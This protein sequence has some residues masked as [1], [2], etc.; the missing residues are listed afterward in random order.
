LEFAQG[1]Y[2]QSTETVIDGGEYKTVMGINVMNQ[3]TLNHSGYN[4]LGGWTILNI[5][6]LTLATNNCNE[7]RILDGSARQIPYQSFGQNR[8]NNT[9]EFGLLVQTEAG[10]NKTLNIYFN[11]SDADTTPDYPTYHFFRD[12]FDDGNTVGWNNVYPCIGTSYNQGINALGTYGLNPYDDNTCSYSYAKSIGNN[13]RWTVFAKNYTEETM[14]IGV[15][16]SSGGANPSRTFAVGGTLQNPTGNFTLLEIGCFSDGPPNSCRVRANYTYEAEKSFDQTSGIVMWINGPGNNITWDEVNLWNFSVY[17]YPVIDIWNF[18]DPLNLTPQFFQCSGGV[19]EQLIYNFTFWKERTEDQLNNNH[20]Y[21]AGTFTTYSEGS[22]QENISSSVSFNATSEVDMCSSSTNPDIRVI[23]N[24]EYVRPEYDTRFYYFFNSTLTPNQNIKLYLLE[25]IYADQVNFHV[26][27]TNDYPLGSNV[28]VFVQRYF[29]STGDYVTVAMLRP[30]EIG[31][32]A[33]YLR[34]VDAWYKFIVTQN[35]ETIYVTTPRKIT[36]TDVYIRVPLSS[37]TNILEKFGNLDASITF[38]NVTRNFTASFVQA[39]GN[40]VEG[41]LEVNR[42]SYGSQTLQCRKCQESSSATL[43][44]GIGSVNGTYTASFYATID[45]VTR[46]IK[47]L[48]VNLATLQAKVYGEDGLVL[49]LFIFL[50]LAFIGLWNP[51]VAIVFG[52]VGLIF[53]AIIG[54]IYVPITIILGLVF[55]GGYLAFKTRT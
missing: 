33:T 42:L 32:D 7:T 37:L 13:F 17:Q 38:N 50:L 14:Y 19:G 52:I 2:I 12:N 6:N 5:T 35:G 28:Y 16:D 53:S 25:I 30:D 44:C 43:I 49:S 9:C 29:P 18:T 26:T 15:R 1:S 54:F 27:D 3:D 20:S 36:E 10:K 21:F 40:T 41:C 55:V 31:D 45:S 4:S 24:I 46:L 8:L 47:T 48:E 22:L 51:S 23:A 11:S 34:K 39:N